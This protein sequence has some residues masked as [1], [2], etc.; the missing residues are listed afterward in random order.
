MAATTVNDRM[1]EIYQSKRSEW[2]PAVAA[3]VQHMGKKSGMCLEIMVTA[4]AH[5][6][7]CYEGL[8]PHEDRAYR[9]D[10]D[11][12]AF[13]AGYMAAE[14]AFELKQAQELSRDPSKFEKAAESL[15]AAPQEIRSLAPTA[16]PKP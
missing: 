6:A 2:P 8:P 9:A 14:A 12:K 7:E 15:T 11:G 4:F 10:D 3:Y 1:N 13:F 16:G 5:Y